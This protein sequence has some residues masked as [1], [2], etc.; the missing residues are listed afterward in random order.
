[1]S[2]QTTRRAFIGGGLALA[3]GA[4]VAKLPDVITRQ[5][6]RLALDVG[7]LASAGAFPSFGTLT[8]ASGS[9]AP[10]SGDLFHR[11][12]ERR[13]GRLSITSIPTDSGILRVHTLDLPDGTV[14]AVGPEGDSKHGISSG[15]RDYKHARGSITVRSGASA[16]LALDVE[17][18]L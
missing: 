10:L 15:T 4:S 11:G 12:S 14:V 2:G 9:K 7:P 3:A 18:E 13:A 6:H 1:M 16:S 17:L 8:P 5:H